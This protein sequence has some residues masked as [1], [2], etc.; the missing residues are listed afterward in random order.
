M[1]QMLREKVI[2][3]KPLSVVAAH[4]PKH[5]RLHFKFNK[6]QCIDTEGK[7]RLLFV[8]QHCDGAKFCEQ[9]FGHF[10]LPNGRLAHFYYGVCRLAC[11]RSVAVP[12]QEC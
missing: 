3:E 10:L 4:D 12:S 7:S 8:T 9:L 6:P 1:L 5:P 2:T 11:L